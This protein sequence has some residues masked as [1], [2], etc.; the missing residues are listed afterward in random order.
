MSPLIFA[1]L[2]P[3]L[4]GIFCFVSP[5]PQKTARLT[6]LAGFLL[7]LYLFFFY[8]RANP[9]Y[10]F[11][12]EYAILPGFGLNFLLGADGFSLVMLLLTTVVTLA[13]V[14]AS[15]VPEKSPGIYYGSLLFISAG[16]IG[17][18]VSVDAFFFYIF[19]ELALIPTFLL[20]GIWGTGDRQA[21]A[22][23][24]TIYLAVG[25]FV[26]LVGLI[27]LYLSCPEGSRTF[28]MRALTQLA[29]NN[30]LATSPLI[31]FLLLF[32]FGT[33]VSLFPFHTWAPSAYA[34]APAPAAMLHAGVLKKFGV[35]GL[36]RLVV[37]I[38]PV[39][40]QQYA[41]IVLALLL[42]NILY[43]GYVAVA[44]KRLDWTLGYSSVMHMGYIFLGFV[45]MNQVSMTGAGIVLF[46]HGLVVAVLF[47]I[48]GVIR[49]KT[50]TLEYSE[51]GGLAQVMPKT[52][53]LFG[54]AAMASIGLPG[55]ANF[56]GELLVFFGAFAAGDIYTGRVFQIATAG[57]IWGIVISA[58][59]MLRAY[60][61]VFFGEMPKVFADLTD[62]AL[63]VRLPLILIIALLLL[64]GFYPQLLIAFIGPALN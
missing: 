54:F 6:A 58:L 32:G 22:W 46:G 64:F 21:A 36:L 13:A 43:V 59:Y 20:I 49:E 45:A 24:A 57:A 12:A 25:S 17:A 50:G 41:N 48:C 19:H 56:A 29:A 14:W 31:Y 34:C 38:F 51:L 53:L 27:L 2:L 1:I 30:S 16:A 26:L 10:Q 3:I 52:G 28:D 60:R 11:M 5:Q 37:P 18:F 42:C 63:A 44:Q 8:D 62:S 61:H 33:L 55:F 4:G 15:S 9:G 23:K 40:I 35:Y 7:T 39:E 47:A